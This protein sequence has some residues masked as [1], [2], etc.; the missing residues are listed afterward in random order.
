[1]A[2]RDPCGLEEGELPHARSLGRRD[3]EASSKASGAS[4][5]SPSPGPRHGS[6]CSTPPRLFSSRF[7]R[8]VRDVDP[9]ASSVTD[10]EPSPDEPSQHPSEAVSGGPSI[11][12]RPGALTARTRKRRSPMAAPMCRRLPPCATLSSH[13]EPTGR[14]DPMLPSLGAA[15]RSVPISCSVCP[16]QAPGGSVHASRCHEASVRSLMTTAQGDLGPAAQPQ[17]RPR[18]PRSP[19][20]AGI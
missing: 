4:P 18:R 17:E 8:R 3:P 10:V 7:I 5:T 9:Y 20:H 2:P 12:G 16:M 19:R 13:G 11:S 1:M 6:S 15:V 14:L